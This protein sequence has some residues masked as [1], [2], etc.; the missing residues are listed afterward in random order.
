MA[1]AAS[2]RRARHSSSQISK[3][4]AMTMIGGTTRAERLPSPVAIRLVSGGRFGASGSTFALAA[5]AIGVAVTGSVLTS[6]M[7]IAWVSSEV[8]RCEVRRPPARAAARHPISARLI[9]RLL[10]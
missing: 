1:A 7:F 9:A 4:K 6:G 2:R 3:V 5:T 8:R 10:R